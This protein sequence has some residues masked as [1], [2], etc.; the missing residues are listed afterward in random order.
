MLPVPQDHRPANFSGAV[1]LFDIEAHANPTEVRVGDPIN[2]TIDIFGSGPLDTLPPPLLASDPALTR[3]FRVP[4]EP[5]AGETRSGTRHF[6]VVIRATNDRITEIPAIEYP[7]FDPDAE[8]FVI[9]RSDP[10]TL[11]VEP[12]AELALPEPTQLTAPGIADGTELQKLDGLHGHCD[13]PAPAA[14]DPSPTHR[15]HG[16]DAHAG[17][18]RGCHC[19]L[20]MCRARTGAPV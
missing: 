9:A 20:G 16:T 5:L 10:I 6:E 2:L 3:D 12:A 1:G 14:G 18:T 19:G 11:E 17:P 4:T 13:Q 15:G 8:R 7:Y